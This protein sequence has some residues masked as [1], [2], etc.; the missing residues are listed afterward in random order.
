MGNIISLAALCLGLCSEQR[1]RP[2][3]WI[4][5]WV[6]SIAPASLRLRRPDS[7]AEGRPDCG[8]GAWFRGDA[9]AAAGAGDPAVVRRYRDFGS[10]FAISVRSEPSWKNHYWTWNHF[11]LPTNMKH[12]WNSLYRLQS[13]SELPA[14]RFEQHFA[15]KSNKSDIQD[16]DFSS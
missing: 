2:A 7:S 12:L 6:E 4:A 10:F 5:W 16:I 9:S 13:I 1:P 3:A 8:G 15:T 11:I 14:V